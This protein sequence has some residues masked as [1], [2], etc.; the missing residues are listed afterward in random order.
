MALRTVNREQAMKSGL[1]AAW[2][3]FTGLKGP[4]GLSVV[5]PAP[6]RIGLA[7]GGGFARGIAHAGILDI[8]DRH[9]IPIHCITGVSAGAIV[10]SAYASGATP[11]E[12]GRAGCA[13]RFGDIARWSIG[14]MGFVV[15]ERMKRFL[16]R[17]LKKY[18][19]EQMQIPLGVVATDLCSGETVN[20]HGSGDVF[21]PIRASCSYPGLFRPVQYQGRLLVDGAMTVETPAQ[22]ARQLGA[23]RVIAVHLAGQGPDIVPGNMFE[24]VNRCFQILQSRAEDNWRKDSDLI[25][26]PSVRSIRWDGFGNGPDLIRAGQAAALEGLPSI[27]NWIDADRE[28]GGLRTQTL[29]RQPA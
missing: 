29:E 2:R 25:L 7:L 14:R 1:L 10:A 28:A 9:S 4:S 15:S 3:R 27:Q 13:M 23:T 21:L 19:F 18:A 8:F 26:T 11:D 22:L 17:L 24:V 20:F 6:L 12:I 5:P 16:E